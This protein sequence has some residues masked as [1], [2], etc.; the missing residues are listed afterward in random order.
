MPMSGF[1]GYYDFLIR[2]MP[3]S[4]VVDLLSEIVILS[5]CIWSYTLVIVMKLLYEMTLWEIEEVI[6]KE[7]QED[8]TSRDMPRT[9]DE[10]RY[11]FER[12]SLRRDR[13]MD[14]YVPHGSWLSSEQRVCIGRTD[15]Q[16]SLWHLHCNCTSLSLIVLS[17]S[18][19]LLTLIDFSCKCYLSFPF[20]VSVIVGNHMVLLIRSITSIALQ[21]LLLLYDLLG[22]IE[23]W[24]LYVGCSILEVWM[25]C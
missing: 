12:C 23:L 15:M 4:D 21:P 17:V 9:E 14:L 13:C 8:V 5:L 6:W 24:F 3:M 7:R 18:D 10:C 2:A 25:M 22:W 1:D 11:E 19:L 20:P 16:Y